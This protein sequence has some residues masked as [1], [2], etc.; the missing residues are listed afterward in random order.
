M[1]GGIGIFVI[2]DYYFKLDAAAIYKASA[3]MAISAWGRGQCGWKRSVWNLGLVSLS[4]GKV[5][6]SSAEQKI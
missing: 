4:S 6:K 5:G 3:A 1:V 2:F